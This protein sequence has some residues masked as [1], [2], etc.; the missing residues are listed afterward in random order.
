V[1]A[2]PGRSTGPAPRRPSAGQGPHGADPGTATGPP[3]RRLPGRAPGSPPDGPVARGPAGCAEGGS[4]GRFRATA[5]AAQAFQEAREYLL[6]RGARGAQG[7]IR[8]PLPHIRATDRFPLHSPNTFGQLRRPGTPLPKRTANHR[9]TRAKRVWPPSGNLWGLATLVRRASR[10][11]PAPRP[12]VIECFTPSCHVD[13][14]AL[15]QLG[16]PAAPDT[17]DSILT[18]VWRGIRSGPRGNVL[19]RETRPVRGAATT[20]GGLAG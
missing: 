8:P 3:R 14:P 7:H 17:V 1:R 5:G 2:L 10:P 12:F 18:V 6:T 13:I 20:E 15:V 11:P 4:G 19:E 16:F 9:S